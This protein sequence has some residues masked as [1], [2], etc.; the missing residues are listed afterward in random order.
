MALGSTQSLIEIGTSNISLGK[1]GQCVGQTTLLTSSTDWPE[2]RDPQPP[3][4]LHYYY[5]YYYYYYHF[6]TGCLHLVP[7]LRMSGTW[8]PPIC[9]PPWL[10]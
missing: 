6:E 2:I 5:Y 7:R 9:M 10:A 3:G 4:T 8:P 1:G